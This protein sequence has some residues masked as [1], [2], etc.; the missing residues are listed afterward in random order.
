MKKT[1]V[2]Y[3][4]WQP[5]FDNLSDEDAAKLIRAIYAYQ[6]TGEEPDSNWSQYATFMMLKGTID[7]DTEAYEAK[8]ERARNIKKDSRDDVD[9]K[10]TRSRNDIDTKSSRK[11]NDIAYVATDTDT[12]TDTET[13]TVSK[14]VKESYGENGNVKLTVKERER[15]IQDY[16]SELTDKA[17]EY[18][19]GYIA[20]KGYKSKSNYQAIRRWVIDAVKEKGRAS[21]EKFDADDYLLKIINGEEDSS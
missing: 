18:L 2:M 10:S 13:D 11:G 3:S 5:L 4:S 9:T 15:L 1:F 6:L 20:D 7:K 19:D 17:I 21:P 16:G 8:V 14:T 12:D